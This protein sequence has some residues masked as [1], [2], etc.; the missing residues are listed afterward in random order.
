MTTQLERAANALFPSTGNLVG[1]VKFFRG[2][3]RRVTADQLADQLLRAD[4]QVRSGEAL[5]VENIDGD[6]TN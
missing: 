4:A 3:A 2:R 5:P 6:L 1:N